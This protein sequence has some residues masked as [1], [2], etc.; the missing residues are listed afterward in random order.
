MH[1]WK[2]HRQPLIVTHDLADDANDPV[3]NHLRHRHLFNAADDPVKMIFHPDF[4]T[5]TNPVMSLDY[6]QFVRGCPHGH[7]PLVLRAVG[8]HP[9]RVPSRSGCRP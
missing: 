8:V 1:A 6:E 4:L 7:L 5:A 3:L 9:A 2:T